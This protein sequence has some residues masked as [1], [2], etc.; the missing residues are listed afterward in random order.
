[1]AESEET[2]EFF[3]VVLDELSRRKLDDDDLREIIR[4]EL[5][6][7]HCYDSRPTKKYHPQT[8]SDY[9]SIWIDE[10]GER[11]FLKLLVANQGTDGERLVVTSFKK[12]N[13][14]V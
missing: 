1:L 4:S 2:C 10:C 13:R 6:E 14:Y 12:D 5:G 8:T 7:S 9:F 3:R 11:M